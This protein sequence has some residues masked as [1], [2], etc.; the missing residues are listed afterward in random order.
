MELIKQNHKT[1]KLCIALHLSDN[2][3]CPFCVVMLT[4]DLKKKAAQLLH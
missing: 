2:L 3:P 1:N 4:Q